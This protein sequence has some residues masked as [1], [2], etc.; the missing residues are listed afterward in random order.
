MNLFRCGTKDGPL[1][2]KYLRL[3]AV[4][5]LL[6]KQVIGRARAIELLAQRYSP[7]EMQTVR[8]TDVNGHYEPGNCRWATASIQVANRRPRSQ[9]EAATH[10]GTP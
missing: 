5:R 4:Y 3:C 2:R 8:S 1:D 7:K 10:R 9:F 6:K